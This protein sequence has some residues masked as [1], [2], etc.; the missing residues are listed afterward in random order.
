LKMPAF[1]WV[2]FSEPPSVPAWLE[3]AGLCL[4]RIFRVAKRA[5]LA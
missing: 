5:R 3:N 2:A 4:G 1:A